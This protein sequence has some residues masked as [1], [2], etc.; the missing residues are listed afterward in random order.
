MKFYKLYLLNLFLIFCFS[1]AE[2]SNPND[3]GEKKPI[4]SGSIKDAQT[5]EQLF[6]ATVYIR[7]LKTGVASNVYGFYSLSIPGGSYTLVYSY[8]GYESFERKIQLKENTT[9]NVELQP[10]QQELKEVVI[11]EKRNNDNVLKNEMSV[12]RMDAKTIRKIP[13][14]MGEVD[15]IKALQL[16]PGIQ[17]TSE[18]S[19]GF[20]VR[21]GSPDQNLILL[22]EA[23]VYNASHLLGFFSV[24]NN[25]AIK[26]VKIYKGDIPMNYGGRLSSVL[27]VRMND[28]NQKNFTACGGIGTISSRLTVE[29]PLIKDKTSFI[30]SG[31]RTYFDLFLPLAAD[32]K[33]RENVLYFYDF[34]AKISHTIN[35]NNRLYLSGYFGRDVFNN[36]FSKLTSGNQTFT[37][38]WN[39][40]FSKKLFSNFMFVYSK[41]DYYLGTP[42]GEANSFDWNSKMRDYG[43]KADF[44]LYADP[45]NTI[46][47]GISSIYHIFDPGMAKGTGSQSFFSEFIV[48][49]TYALE[50]GLYLGNDQ[51]INN[52]INMK[53]GLRFSMFQNVGPATI[54]NY[55]KNFESTDSTVYTS[56]D[57]Y[58]TYSG[59]EPRFG[60][61]YTIN[62][63]SS[64]KANYSRTFQYIQLA[65]NSTS[66]T[67]L[68]VWFPAS[69]NI[70]P[71]LCDQFALGY[72]RNFIGNYLETSVEVYY[73]KMQNAIDFKDH[74]ELLLNQ[75]LEG[76]LRFGEATS[77]GLEVLV[78]IPEGRINGWIS[79]TFSR[80]DRDFPDINNGNNYLAYYD[81]P[82]NIAI[83]FNYEISKRTTFSANWIYYTGSPV[84]FPT[85]RADIGG[86]IVPIYSDRNAYRMPDYHRLD[87][88]LTIKSKQK[89]NRKW[90]SEWN[91]SLY[92]AYGRKNAWA[93]NFRQDKDNPDITY[94]EKTYLFSFIPAI[95][96]NFKF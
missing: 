38:R 58:K 67:P 29:G 93:I 83:V 14:F 10:R 35:E 25:D 41:Y 89:P 19:S 15:V 91:F 28:G 77:K 43:L 30:M 33:I 68:D 27:D 73:K 59:I 62:D 3:G 16:L 20:S 2:A 5:G 88:A 40:L 34:N 13:A 48:P 45:K 24:F 54:F 63:Q 53:Y 37:L 78:K 21:G 65:Q 7:E 55:N 11:S 95:T 18:G 72:F 9:I 44:T 96:Y 61:A 66:G 31:R 32:E 84:T 17:T 42:E 70:K 50:N 47:F 46:K 23:T 49:S 69:P 85:G 36:D 79:Y 71:Q 22:D 75:K 92:N 8:I 94:A 26:D 86:K 80:T 57:I 51:K 1:F 6:G 52:K 39:H 4:I 87:L 64:V 60:I 74:A 12:V 82:H 90:S 56:G 76:E 81:K